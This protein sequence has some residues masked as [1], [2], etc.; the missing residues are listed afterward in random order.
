MNEEKEYTSEGSSPKFFN[1]SKKFDEKRNFLA[2]LLVFFFKKIFL[3]KY[4]EM[5]GK[6]IRYVT[7]K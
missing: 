6:K 4:Q 1:T 2:V 7:S 3:K 5:K